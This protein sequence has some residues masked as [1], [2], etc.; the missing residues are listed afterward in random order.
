[1]CAFPFLKNIFEFIFCFFIHLDIGN[2][3]FTVLLTTK[4]RTVT[5]LIFGFSVRTNTREQQGLAMWRIPQ[6]KEAEYAKYI[7][8]SSKERNV[9]LFGS[10]P[11][12]F[13]LV[14][15]WHVEVPEPGIEPV[16]QQRPEPLQQQC[17][18]LNPLHHKG[19]P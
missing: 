1:M 7:D 6:E 2:S 11:P 19:N 9:D 18:I 8:Y 13:F 10:Y 14:Y 17:W 5:Q 16:P 12:C 3:D 15:L 4:I